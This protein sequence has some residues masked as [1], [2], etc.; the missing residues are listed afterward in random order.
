MTFTTITN[1]IT[2]LPDGTYRLAKAKVVS[3]AT[4]FEGKVKMLVKGIALEGKVQ[5][6]KL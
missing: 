1:N 2:T 3:P 5:Y 6:K 4:I